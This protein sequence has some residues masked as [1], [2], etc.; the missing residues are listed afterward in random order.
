MTAKLITTSDYSGPDRRATNGAV[1]KNWLIGILT[2]LVIGI[3][4]A[5]LSSLQAQV[6]SHTQ[7]IPAL[8]KASEAVG[9]RLDRIETKL[10]R[11]IERK[12]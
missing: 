5:W 9:A 7:A 6:Y 8:Q 1:T 3:G 4:G 11:L 10:D 2:A 12:V